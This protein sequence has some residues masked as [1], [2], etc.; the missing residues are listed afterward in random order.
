[1]D[2]ARAAA[3]ASLRERLARMGGMPGVSRSAPPPPPAH[4]P[5]HPPEMREPGRTILSPPRHLDASLQNLGFLPEVTPSGLAWV[6]RA[7]V[8]LGPFLEAAGAPAPA[9]AGQLVRLAYAMPD[10]QPDPSWS[11]DAV[12]VLDIETL[13][14]H[15]SGVVA[16]LV[17]I[18]VPC[19]TR[20][21]VDQLLLA[22][23][24]DEPALLL[25]VLSR[26]ERI[27]MVVTYNGRTFDLPI[28]R[29]RCIVNRVAGGALDPP[30]HCD[31]LAPVRRL[32]RDRLGACTLRQAEGALLRLHRDEDVPGSEAPSRYRA[33]LRGGDAAVVEGVVRHN[34][35]DLCAT[36][37]LAARLAAHVDGAR[38]EPAHPA[39]RYR[40]GVHL[41]RGGGVREEVAREVEE[42]YR[43]TLRRA[44][45]PWDRHA[46][47]RLARRLRRNG[48]EA[49]CGEAVAILRAIWERD[50]DDLRVGRLLAVTLERGGCRLDE[51][52]AVC[53]RALAACA[54]LGEWRLARM[55]GAPRGGWAADWA[56]RRRRLAR[57]RELAERRARRAARGQTP[58]P[59]PAG[60][61]GALAGAAPPL[62]ASWSNGICQSASP[63]DASAGRLVFLTTTTS[64]C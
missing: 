29:G 54:R 62:F 1:M 24:D 15:G 60:A 25:A 18:G 45:P 11:E 2:P 5:S 49:G 3:V 32:F 63:S 31:L 30:L 43:A 38:V 26:L 59:P 33:W 40:L 47:L 8:E 55:R 23:L 14:L 35:L 61:A 41:E 9:G 50:P 12:A 44:V 39:D 57:R 64:P 13:G 37:V 4:A 28:L 22:D 16:F 52:L 56:R 51:A 6:R 27:R 34:E 36:M 48:G 42:H 19:G 7:S 10:P 46:A 21:A 20:L 58:P 53:D 17:G